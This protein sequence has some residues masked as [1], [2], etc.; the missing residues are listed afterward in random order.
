LS[1]DLGVERCVYIKSGISPFQVSLTSTAVQGAAQT[2]SSDLH[3]QR[4]KKTFEKLL[5]SIE[6]NLWITLVSRIYG[7]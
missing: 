3:S 2:I 6:E 5:H 1:R 7:S 4:D